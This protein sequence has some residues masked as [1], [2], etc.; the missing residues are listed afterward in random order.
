MN[1]LLFLLSNGISPSFGRPPISPSKS[2]YFDSLL[3]QQVGLLLMVSWIIHSTPLYHPVYTVHNATCC[4]ELVKSYVFN[5]AIAACIPQHIWSRDKTTK[6][7]DGRQNISFT[8]CKE[9][10]SSFSWNCKRTK[11]WFFRLWLKLRD[12]AHW[13]H[14]SYPAVAPASEGKSKIF[15]I[16]ELTTRL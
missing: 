1:C 7:Q 15:Q 13:H 6:Y 9:V 11:I 4:T 16:R 2:S 8:K 3:F 12:T 10:Q 5:L 14:P